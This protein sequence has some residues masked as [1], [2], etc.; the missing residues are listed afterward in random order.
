[1]VIVKILKRIV[2]ELYI[3]IFREYIDRDGNIIIY[4]DVE[5]VIKNKLKEMM[6][7]EKYNYYK[8]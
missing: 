8:F 2:Y 5:S 4:R 6:G 3:D 7:G 1:M